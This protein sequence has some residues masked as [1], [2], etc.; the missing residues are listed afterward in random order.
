MAAACL[1]HVL[2]AACD[3]FKIIIDIDNLHHSI[4]Q[5]IKFRHYDWGKLDRPL[6]TVHVWTMT[7]RSKPVFIAINPDVELMI[8]QDA[9]HG[10]HRLRGEQV[11]AN[12]GKIW[13]YE[14]A[15]V[16]RGDRKSK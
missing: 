9:D 12:D 4:Q 1:L 7:R 13:S 15:A 3:G 16:K 5:T 10:L 8:C 6:F 11:F 14:H 2:F